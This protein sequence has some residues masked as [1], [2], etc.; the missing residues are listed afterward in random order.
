MSALQQ[1]HKSAS[2]SY[3]PRR[4]VFDSTLVTQGKGKAVE[5]LKQSSKGE[6]GQAL[7]PLHS[8]ARRAA[9]LQGSCMRAIAMP[10]ASLHCQSAQRH[11]SFSAKASSSDERRRRPPPHMASSP[12]ASSQDEHHELPMKNRGYRQRYP[13]EKGPA[14]IKQP[15]KRRQPRVEQAPPQGLIWARAQPEEP[16]PELP[17][18]DDGSIYAALKAHKKARERR[19][20]LLLGAPTPE[21]REEAE[22]HVMQTWDVYRA[23][24]MDPV[25][26]REN[27]RLGRRKDGWE[28]WE[29]MTAKEKIDY[30]RRQREKHQPVPEASEVPK[31]RY[32]G[33]KGSALVGGQ[34]LVD[35]N[36]A[37]LEA[38]K[39]LAGNPPARPVKP[40]VYKGGSPTPK[41]KE[42]P[43]ASRRRR[44]QLAYWAGG[45]LTDEL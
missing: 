32:P 13:W 24:G 9:L 40:P 4:S 8:A 41:G 16:T 43:I 26:V 27:E 23:R 22:R 37:R 44:K 28:E 25:K 14:L 12:A 6:P 33:D 31:Q 18:G 11:L 5:G 36:Q 2:V 15:S 19:R 30:E 21:A 20:K 39:K 34:N 45:E 7:L 17:E 38:W 3:S 35:A 42:K 10:A 1:Q 29:R